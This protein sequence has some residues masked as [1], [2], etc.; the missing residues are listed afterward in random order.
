MGAVFG[1]QGTVCGS[2]VLVFPTGDISCESRTESVKLENWG[3]IWRLEKISGWIG[4]CFRDHT[5][6]KASPR[7]ARLKKKTLPGKV[8][9][10]VLKKVGYVGMNKRGEYVPGKKIK[11]TVLIHPTARYLVFLSGCRCCSQVKENVM[12]KK[13]LEDDSFIKLREAQKEA[14]FLKIYPGIEVM[15]DGSVM[16]SN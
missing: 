6:K 2:E 16:Q 15:C 10:R 14:G 11:P 5:S 9:Q 4:M 8:L 3:L 12:T 1:L 13:P 7:G